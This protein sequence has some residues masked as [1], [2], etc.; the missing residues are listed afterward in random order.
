MSKGR[1]HGRK[2]KHGR[3]SESWQRE[4]INEINGFPFIS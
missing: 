1:R 3:K 2:T 4:E